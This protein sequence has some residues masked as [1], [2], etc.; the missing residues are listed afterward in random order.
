MVSICVTVYENAKLSSR[1]A[2]GFCIPTSRAWELLL[3]PV[4]GNV[5]CCQCSGFAHSNSC[6]VV[7]HCCCFLRFYLCNF[8]ERGGEGEKYWCERE[9]LI[10]GLL[11]ILLL[12]PEPTTQACA[13]M[14]NQIVDLLLCVM[15]PNPLSHTGQGW[16]LII[17]IHLSLMTYEV[18]HLFMCLFVIF[19]SPSLRC[20]LQPLAHF[21]KLCCFLILNF[22]CSLYILDSSPLWDVSL[23]SIFSL[24]VASHSLHS[25]F[26]RAEVF[27]FFK[28]FIIYF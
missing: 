26:H 28:D 2:V 20:L 4:P 5:P 7:S 16:Y 14:G 8:R 21:L 22:K 6:I 27:F 3:L 12:G 13:L 15:V 11:C 17:F 9:P 25:A 19:L 10:S 1:M 18:E 24:S 23:A